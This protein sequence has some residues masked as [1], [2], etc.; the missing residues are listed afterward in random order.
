MK[1]DMFAMEGK[2]DTNHKHHDDMMMKHEVN[3]HMHHSKMYSEHKAGHK[4]NAEQVKAMC[5]GGYTK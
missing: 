5:G 4:T 2:L 1:G 3:G